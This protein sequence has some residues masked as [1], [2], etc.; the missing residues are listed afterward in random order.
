MSTFYLT[1]ATRHYHI[2]DN[3][4]IPASGGRVLCGR[5]LQR[6]GTLEPIERAGCLLESIYMCRRCLAAYERAISEREAVRA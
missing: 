3:P 2:A 4:P 6:Y 1:T 5:R